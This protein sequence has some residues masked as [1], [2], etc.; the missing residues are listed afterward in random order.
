MDV[1]FLSLP[2]DI[3][4]FILQEWIG[5]SDCRDFV[6]LDTS[7]CNFVCREKYVYCIINC[8]IGYR[9]VRSKE[10]TLARKRLECFLKW[11]I[12]RKIKLTEFSLN[13][14]VERLSTP[15]FQSLKYLS[16]GLNKS[17]LCL[18]FLFKSVPV[19][20][21]LTLCGT[22][23]L[24]FNLSLETNP[25][26]LRLS[27]VTLHMRSIKCSGLQAILKFWG[28]YANALQ[29]V[30]F[31]VK[32]DTYDDF[33]FAL[34]YLKAMKTFRYCNFTQPVES[35]NLRSLIPSL[36][37]HEITP[38]DATTNLFPQLQTLS[39][40]GDEIVL[41]PMLTKFPNLQTLQVQS[42]YFGNPYSESFGQTLQ[43]AN[44]P[45]L[46]HFFTFGKMG[47]SFVRLLL[48]FPMNIFQTLRIIDCTDAITAVIVSRFSTSLL[49]LTLFGGRYAPGEVGLLHFHLVS[50]QCLVELHLEYIFV[51]YEMYSS[52]FSDLIISFS[53]PVLTHFSICVA[54][55]EKNDSWKII[56]CLLRSSLHLQ[57][58][59]LRIAMNALARRWQEES[60]GFIEGVPIWDKLDTLLLDTLPIYPICS[61]LQKLPNLR[62]LNVYASLYDG[63]LLRELFSQETFQNAK[64]LRVFKCEVPPDLHI[65]YDAWKTLLQSCP[66]L[67]TFTLYCWRNKPYWQL[68][69]A[70]HR[71]LLQEFQQKINF[72]DDLND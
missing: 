24:K 20:Q 17:E 3:V 64:N 28:L 32:I 50:M 35:A 29:F 38:N 55:Q 5:R 58:K 12:S 59:W 71:Q 66:T 69:N 6:S 27:I 13:S 2:N 46:K 30:D 54:S 51:P 60:T 57:L 16:V 19:L 56:Q 4:Q 61:L 15:Q 1:F 65:P 68:K 42:S 22:G 72:L 9:E 53:F 25:V 44:F 39:Y 47:F 18:N 48:S 26:P 31:E 41:Q 14:K 7:M 62:N 10:P 67:H 23:I 21:H 45:H 34:N 36:F 11:V 33:L 8:E 49:K 63:I 52:F 40:L 43:A 70:E 37:T